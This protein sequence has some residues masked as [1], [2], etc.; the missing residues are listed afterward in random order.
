MAGK[1]R[2]DS[3][4]VVDIQ[5]KFDEQSEAE[6]SDSITRGPKGNYDAN[7]IQVLDG[8]EA[9][10]K[11][12]AMYISNTDVLGLHHLVYEAVD[13]SVD[14]AMGGYCDKIFVTIHFDNSIT[15]IDNGRGIPVGPHPKF[16]DKSAAEVALTM[17]H[18]G[19]KFE[20]AAYKYSGG[21]HG[22]GV[23]V[24]NFL[25]EWF[26]VEIKRD[27]GVYFM[28]F[29]DGGRVKQPLEKIGKTNKMGTRVRFKPDTRIFSN[30]EFSFETL[31]NR[32]RELAFLNA[33][34]QINIED[35]RSSKS[36]AF[37]YAGGICEFVKHL[38]RNKQPVF[39]QPIHFIKNRIYERADGQ[40][41]EIICEVSIQYND[42]YDEQVYTFA[43]NINTRDGGMH[44]TGFRKALTTTINKYAQKNDLLK[45]MKEGLSGD[46]M[47]EGLVAVLSVKVTD[48]QFEGQNKGKLLNSEVAGLVEQVVNEGLGEW[49]EEN[50]REAKRMIEKA[51]MAAQA[52]VAARKAR[53]IVR[54][55][56]MEGGGLPGKLAD[57]SGKGP[58][59]ELY[60]VEGDSAGGSAKQGRDRHFQAILPLRGKIINVQKAR[61]DK[62]L[63]N[64]EIRTIV[65]ALG[66]GIGTEH[67]EYEKLR[68]G[69]IILMT[70]AD[71]DGA[72]IRTLLL[73]FFYR[74]FRDLIE[75]GHIYI[76]QPPLYRVKK[77]KL[78]RY[79][80]KDEDKDRFLLEE[81]ID[82]LEL[83]VRTNGS[84]KRLGKL[85]IREMAECLIELGK[86]SQS[87]HRKGITFDEY[88]QLADSH[89][90]LPIAMA[91]Q[92]EQRHYA[93]TE[94]ELA[95]LEEEAAELRE[96]ANGH[97]GNGNGNGHSTA[98]GRNGAK[99]APGEPEDLFS[100]MA[101]EEVLQ[102]EADEDDEPVIP[103]D[104]YEFAESREIESIIKRLARL[105]LSMQLYRV[106]HLDRQGT[107][108]DDK[109]PL[110]VSEKDRDEHPCHSLAEAFDIVKS[111]GSKGIVIQ[112]Y[113]GLGEMNAEQLW[114]TTM[115][116]KTRTLRRVTLD[117]AVEAEQI[118]TTLMGEEVTTRRAFIQRHAPEV[119]NLDI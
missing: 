67:F 79:L 71:V 28:R 26:E 6:E 108:T 46:D 90:H 55:S 27:G 33:G 42:S 80:E 48:P 78:S 84:E 93:Y 49:L 68:Y 60:L 23:S 76:A 24:V 13:N 109:A 17:L 61:L 83:V 41:D 118:F 12:P 63:S 57:C 115:N 111:L 66:T 114:E 4:E 107:G 97:N 75:R 37:K 53:E 85:Q 101:E 82:N 8:R 112:R 69:K 22:V 21:L 73:T 65:T 103:M 3:N 52:R 44:L 86:I 59:T 94:K 81:G 20:H 43:N 16:P 14:E 88:L 2:K 34:L 56:V 95:R 62:V 11:R 64:E 35:E 5:L 113:K 96:R 99:P 50:P 104:I 10:R 119:R 39:A 70:D 87:I 106:G 40:Q 30:I 58:D 72:H 38:N 29:E 25:A 18:A 89:G 9:V 31:S 117:D 105:G 98:N 45:K 47:R 51:V 102:D 92:A 36:H 32:L 54:K 74:Q 77:G 15:V 19:G 116:P 1:S 7:S 100:H 91:Q 110:V